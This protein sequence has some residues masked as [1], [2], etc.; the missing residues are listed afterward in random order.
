MPETALVPA[1]TPLLPAAPP[2]AALPISPCSASIGIAVASVPTKNPASVADGAGAALAGGA[3]D[4]GGTR[5]GGSTRAGA[6]GATGCRG[7]SVGGAEGGHDDKVSN[8]RG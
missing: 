2:S 7:Q 5:A 3:T 1:A 6:A 4:G 8:L